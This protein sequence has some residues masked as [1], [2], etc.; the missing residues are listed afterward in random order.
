VRAREPCHSIAVASN[1]QTQSLEVVRRP[2]KCL[3]YCLYLIDREFGWMH[4]RLQTW[5]PYGYLRLTLFT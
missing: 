5:A 2:R 3:H 1:R 4:V